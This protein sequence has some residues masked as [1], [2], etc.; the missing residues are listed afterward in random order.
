MRLRWIRLTAGAALA[1]AALMDSGAARADDLALFNDAVE[2]FATHN[3]TALGYLRTENYELAV[4]ELDQM[5][6]TWS[7]FAERFGGNRP[8]P[9]RDNKL[10]VTMLVDVPTRIV[11][12]MMMVDFGRP[13]IAAN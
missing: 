10:Y 6:D 12:A 7:A 8:A 5:K 11:T 1:A 9:F 13:Q 3:R 2:D 4:T